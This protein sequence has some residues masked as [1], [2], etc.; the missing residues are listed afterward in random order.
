ML[1]APRARA[2]AAGDGKQ[3][4]EIQG[5]PK[6]KPTEVTDVKVDDKEAVREV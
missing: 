1:A 4:I 5:A 6:K 3:L 2:K